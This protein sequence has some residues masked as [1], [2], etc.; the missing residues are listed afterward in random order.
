MIAGLFMGLL[1]VSSVGLIKLAHGKDTET[2]IPQVFLLITLLG[3]WSMSLFALIL[4]TS[5]KDF[6][7]AL[8]ISI[9][10]PIALAIWIFISRRHRKA[11]VHIENH[12]DSSV[13]ESIALVEESTK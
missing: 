13:E 1:A 2:K 8:V 6:W 9:I 7:L 10:I 5:S 11:N 4:N 3:F 12:F